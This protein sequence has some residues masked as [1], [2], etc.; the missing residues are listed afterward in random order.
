M[1]ISFDAATDP[2][3]PNARK[4]KWEKLISESFVLLNSTLNYHRTSY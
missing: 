4:A 3:V 1:I 2:Y